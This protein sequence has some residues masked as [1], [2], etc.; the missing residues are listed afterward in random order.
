MQGP[1][2]NKPRDGTQPVSKR[3]ALPLARRL[4]SGS[5]WALAGKIL[6]AGGG[7][8]ANA[9]IARLLSPQEVGAY[10]LLV[11]FVTAAVLVAQF[12]LQRGVV[13]LVAQTL[14]RDPPGDVSGI[15]R[16]VLRFGLGVSL[17]VAFGILLGGRAVAT[18]LFH[19]PL[20]SSVMWLGAIWVVLRTLLTL[21]AEAFRGL[22][23][24]PL[25]VTFN[26]LTS[27]LV[28]ILLLSV[29]LWCSCQVDLTSIVLTGGFATLTSLAAA[30]VLMRRELGVL[31][32]T[33]TVPLGH[34]A[35]VG[36]PLL[37][38][39]LTVFIFS[40]ADLWVVGAFR[41]ASDVAMYGA[42][43]RLVQLV[44][45]PLMIVNAVLPPVIS[46]L[47]KRGQRVQLEKT[48]RGMA[49]IAGIPAI[50]TLV[51]IV[52]AA[53]RIL[54]LVYGGYYQGAAEILI[55]VSAGQLVNVWAGS[56]ILLLMMTDH[57][58][59]L[60]KLTALFAVLLVGAD[61]LAVR[62]YGTVGVAATSGIVMALQ[63]LSVLI[64][65]KRTTGL[66]CHLGLGQL[67]FVAKR[68]NKLIK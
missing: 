13:R 67:F 34:L 55:L 20:L 41:P 36:A 39:S 24:I 54:G 31:G 48:L 42:A 28:L 27:N 16:S 11:S 4:L 62:N 58:T 38:T 57:Q 64:L 5:A 26:G 59:P 2:V 12:G 22:H 49:T 32:P 30:A 8:V 17:I 9:M 37:V 65:A 1:D 56:G 18:Q 14:A 10:F 35:R 47:H 45:T 63:S 6:T 19:S 53:S 51:I 61:I 68:L 66:W 23:H 15:I 33:M 40:Q 25:A 44:A 50:V 52:F 46:D 3:L 29:Y 43:T 7:L 21:H 60:M